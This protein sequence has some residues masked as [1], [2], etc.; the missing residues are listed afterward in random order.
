MDKPFHELGELK[1]EEATS[2]ATQT[3]NPKFLNCRGSAA[4]LWHADHQGPPARQFAIGNFRQEL[5]VEAHSRALLTRYFVEKVH[6][7]SPKSI[8]G[9]AAF[10]K[11]EGANRIHFDLGMFTQRGAQVALESERPLPH[12]RHGER[13]NPI[14]HS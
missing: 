2:L 13:N 4:P 8:L 6:D 9:P 14:W 12:L 5:Q 3:T 10:I 7:V 11:V 1:A